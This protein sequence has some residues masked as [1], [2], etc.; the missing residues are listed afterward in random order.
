M[1][2]ETKIKIVEPP[3]NSFLSPAVFGSGRTEWRKEDHSARIRRESQRKEGEKG[4]DRKTLGRR[5]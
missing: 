4:K 3:N 5:E 1:V 2:T